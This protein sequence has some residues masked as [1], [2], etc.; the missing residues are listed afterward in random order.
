MKL[1]PEQ[2][3][4]LVGECRDPKEMASLYSQMLQHMINQLAGSGDAVAPGL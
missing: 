3:A 4:A 2:L 1:T